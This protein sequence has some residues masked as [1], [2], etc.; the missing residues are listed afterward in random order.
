MLLQASQNPPQQARVSFGFGGKSIGFHAHVSFH[1]QRKPPIP[2]SPSP[3]SNNLQAATAAQ[4]PNNNIAALRAAER[5]SRL[6]DASSSSSLSS[7]VGREGLTSSS[8]LPVAEK[9]SKTKAHNVQKHEEE[10]ERFE[11]LK[12]DIRGREYVY[13]HHGNVVIVSHSNPDRLS[14]SEK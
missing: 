4:A 6:K 9:T 13:D 8:Q 5:K 11:K 2:K 10:H 3:A 14:I 7:T 12:K 1:F